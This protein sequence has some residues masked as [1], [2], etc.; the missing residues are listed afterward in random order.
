VIEHRKDQR[1]ADDLHAFG[2]IDQIRLGQAQHGPGHREGST[3]PCR[4]EE[5]IGI[6]ERC[7]DDHPPYDFKHINITET[8]DGQRQSQDGEAQEGLGRAELGPVGIQ[9]GGVVVVR[10]VGQ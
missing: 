2:P 10:R 5:K 7:E 8:Q 4:S 3:D 9:D 1:D 6:R